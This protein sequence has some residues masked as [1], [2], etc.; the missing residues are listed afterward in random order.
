[1]K[2]FT[3]T[4]LTTLPISHTIFWGLINSLCNLALEK[5]SRHENLKDPE[6]FALCVAAGVPIESKPLPDKNVLFTLKRPCSLDLTGGAI[7]ILS[8][9]YP[10]S[11]PD[12]PW[13]QAH[14]SK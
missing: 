2:Q 11:Q 10:V 14:V 6:S 13:V 5:I 3:L 9:G 4:I 8:L 1:M 7:K 12:F